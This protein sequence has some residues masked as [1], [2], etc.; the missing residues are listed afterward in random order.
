MMSFGLDYKR[1]CR[2]GD[3]IQ[4][5]GGDD[6]GI[7]FV[8]E[9]ICQLQYGEYVIEKLQLLRIK[10]KIGYKNKKMNLINLIR[11]GNKKSR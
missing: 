8:F 2:E 3:M 7:K 1:F 10:V 9:K 11:V 6:G 5:W 4:G